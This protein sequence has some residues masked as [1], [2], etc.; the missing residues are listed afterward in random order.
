MQVGIGRNL[1]LCGTSHAV[2][3]TGP[4]VAFFDSFLSVLSFLWNQ[5]ATFLQV[6][7]HTQYL[8]C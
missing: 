6:V 4:F 8:S 2:S 5:S 1:I 3:V 7:S